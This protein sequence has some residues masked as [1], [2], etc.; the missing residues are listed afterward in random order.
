MITPPESAPE[1]DRRVRRRRGR[2]S[3]F[4]LTIT[5]I[6]GIVLLLISVPNLAPALRAARAEGRP[7]TFVAAQR[8][9]VH[10]LSHE[11]CS[12]HGSFTSLD[13][14]EQHHDTYLYGNVALRPGQRVSAIDVGRPGHVYTG[15]SREWVLT[16]ALLVLG[17]ALLVVPPA[18]TVIGARRGRRPR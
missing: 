14:R 10:H 8:S 9:C 6:T 7:G 13:G 12:W 3:A 5:T 16:V 11:S 1:A 4:S 17:A 15:P 2:P 18:R